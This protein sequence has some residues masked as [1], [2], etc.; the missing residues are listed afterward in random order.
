[1]SESWH[2]ARDIMH[3]DKTDQS[4][5]MS[6][7]ISRYLLVIKKMHDIL[8]STPLDEKNKKKFDELESEYHKL[9]CERGTIIK[10]I[11]RVERKE[12]SHYLFEDADFSGDTVKK[13]IQNGERDAEKILVD[14][15][16][17]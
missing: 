8:E 5:R 13:L 10:E 11:V 14:F 17:N 9:A 6:K 2:R 4:V 15:G 3:T 12:E 1:M 16:K 7:I